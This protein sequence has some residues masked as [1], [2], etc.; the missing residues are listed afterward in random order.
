MIWFL[1]NVFSKNNIYENILEYWCIIEEYH[2]NCLQS[3]SEE[4]NYLT[5]FSSYIFFKILLVR[6]SEQIFNPFHSVIIWSLN[7]SV[8]FL[9]EFKLFQ[10]SC[11]IILV[12]C[13][14]ISDGGEQ[15]SW[16]SGLSYECRS[17]L[18]KALHNL[19]ERQVRV[20]GTIWIYS[21][22]YPSI[23]N[24]QFCIAGV[25]YLVVLLGWVSGLFSRT[26]DP[27]K[28]SQPGK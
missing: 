20:S 5:E 22:D 4:I 6:F 14:F 24:I 18:F 9:F 8:Q 1:G 2:W 28:L 23:T 7:L 16:E 27:R 19:I 15:G 10:F 26:M 21:S 3:R 13:S 25:Y 17:L 12:I 11:F